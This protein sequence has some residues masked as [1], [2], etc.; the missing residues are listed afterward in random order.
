MAENTRIAIVVVGYNRKKSMLRLIDSLKKAE[1]KGEQV[2]LIISLDKSPCID[3]MLEAAES[4]IWTFGNK[5]I[6]TFDERQGLRKHIIQCG[7]LTQVYDSVI[8]LEDDLV[9]SKYFYSYVCD[10]VRKYGDSD[11]IAGISLYSH[12]TVPGI[13]RPFVPDRNQYDVYFMQYAQSWG[14]CWTKKMWA[15]FIAWY[16]VAKGDKLCSDGV[17]PEYV[18]NW[19]D[20]SWL[21][22]YIKYT[23]ENNKYFVYP[24]FSL[25]TNASESGEH[26]KEARTAFQVPLLSGDLNYRLPD[27][28]DGIKYDAFFERMIPNDEIL[29]HLIGI[30]CLDLNG[31]RVSFKDIDYLISTN[32]LPFGICEEYGLQFRPH[33][34]NVINQVDGKGIYVYDI[35]KKRTIKRRRN[36]SA[37]IAYDVQALLWPRALEYGIRGAY[38]EIKSKFKR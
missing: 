3:E 28:K 24:Y 17:I 14:Q 18:V 6:R 10:T 13:Y 35:H 32:E 23:A 29:P 5:K 33:E 36:T 22:Y 15:G 12:I 2:D 31:L 21:K 9:V 27:L 25:T 7:N 1:Y 16:D 30:K 4:I 11:D 19:D 38:K 26:N 34:Y 37:T 8:V 20:K